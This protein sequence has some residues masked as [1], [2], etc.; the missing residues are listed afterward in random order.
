LDLQALHSNGV[1]LKLQSG[2]PSGLP[3]ILG[4]K[5][6]LGRTLRRFDTSFTSASFGEY[7]MDTPVSLTGR[8]IHN[9]DVEFTIVQRESDMKQLQNFIYSQRAST[10]V[11]PDPNAPSF[12]RNSLTEPVMII[13]HKLNW[14]KH[15]LWELNLILRSNV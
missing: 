6:P 11:W 9:N 3:T 8:P 13:G 14:I 12:F 4:Y 1:Q 15:N 5:K 2:I 10:F 7:G